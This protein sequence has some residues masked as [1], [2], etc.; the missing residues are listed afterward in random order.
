MESHSNQ[1]PTSVK[2][3]ILVFLGLG[4]LTGMTVLLSYL[5]LPH[6]TAIAL[7][8]LIATVKCVLIATFFMHLRF[9][10]RGFL[11]LLFTALF[12]VAVL[13]GSLIQDLGFH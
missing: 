5:G 13:I 3:Y 11:Y 10:K 8:I 6:T 7:A 9:E 4:L 1:H 2:P 12:F